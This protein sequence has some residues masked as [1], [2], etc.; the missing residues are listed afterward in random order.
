MEKDMVR[1]SGDAD[2][3]KQS[4]RADAMPSAKDV[5]S[6]ANANDRSRHRRH[7]WLHEDLLA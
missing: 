5:R 4:L 2:A 3:P 7:A 1:N 6:V